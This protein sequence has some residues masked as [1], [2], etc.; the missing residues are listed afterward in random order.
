MA[1]RWV[2]SLG[3]A[4][5]EKYGLSWKVC[6]MLWDSWV[7]TVHSFLNPAGQLSSRLSYA[8]PLTRYQRSH[9]H[10][11]LF[12]FPKECVLFRFFLAIW[13]F[14]YACCLWVIGSQRQGRREHGQWA[15]WISPV[16]DFSDGFHSV[17]YRTFVRKRYLQ[18]VF[19]DI[20]NCR[21]VLWL[22][23]QFQ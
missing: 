14:S 11:I 21:R 15:S 16:N 19:C 1:N 2:K 3:P 6:V 4:L 12:C 23:V 5:W 9:N 22:E 7:C 13:L 18:N 17:S 20:F 8:S 10:E